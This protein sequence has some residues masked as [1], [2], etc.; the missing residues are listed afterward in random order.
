MNIRAHRDKS[1]R[2]LA[3]D[4][5]KGKSDCRHTYVLVEG[6]NDFRVWAKF[7]A[8]L[9]QIVIADG[10]DKLVAKLRYFN[11]NYPHWRNV[12]AIVD[13][14]FWLLE[15]ANELDTENLLYD[16]MPSLE[17]TLIASPALET[18]LVN[19]LPVDVAASYGEQL[20]NTALRLATEYGY[21]RLLDYRHRKY[22]LSF[23]QVSF[24]AVID[25]ETLELD[26]IRIAASLVSNSVLSAS[27][28]LEHI[29]EL[30]RKVAP[31]IRLCR[32]HDVLNIMAC[33][34]GF[35]ADL[36]GKAKI[37][38]KSNELSRALRMAY[39][40]TDFITTQ[41]YSRIRKWKSENIPFRIIQDFPLERTAP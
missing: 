21:Y 7:K 23:N 24:D 15:N 4:L 41:L 34:I 37:Q 1:N 28:L 8:H 36:S 6:S 26:E 2:R 40:F 30:R 19:T 12:A 3:R 17:L 5:L 13:P 9:C 38:T 29:K 18:V 25:T 32:G 10:K 11:T 14:D 39:E 33:L 35:D 20:R 27:Q 31:D 22:N 16:D